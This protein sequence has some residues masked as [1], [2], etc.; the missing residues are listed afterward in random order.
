M[1]HGTIISV[2]NGKAVRCRLTRDIV[3]GHPPTLAI[4]TLSASRQRLVVCAA[5]IIPIRIWKFHDDI[6]GMNQA[7]EIS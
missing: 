5:R 7:G 6:P 1:I 3:V 4:L 2:Y